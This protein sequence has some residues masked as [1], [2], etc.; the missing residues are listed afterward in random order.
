[1]YILHKLLSP[2]VRSFWTPGTSFV[3]T[4]IFWSKWC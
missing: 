1:M 4:W 3:Q 2:G